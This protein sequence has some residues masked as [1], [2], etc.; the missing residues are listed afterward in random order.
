MD[1]QPDALEI[2]AETQQQT[3]K[4]TPKRAA[5]EY[6]RSQGASVAEAAKSA[7]INQF[8]GYRI[9]RKVKKQGLLRPKILK[10]VDQAQE[11]ILKDYIAGKDKV[12]T[13]AAAM[14]SETEARRNPVVRQ[15]LNLNANVDVDPIDFSQLLNSYRK[16]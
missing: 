14:I 2:K 4:I 13:Q 16:G 1:A 8:H 11:K 15:N 5:Y 7:G 10:L 3:E 12:V 9:E 6:F